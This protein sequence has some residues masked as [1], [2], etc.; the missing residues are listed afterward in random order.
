MQSTSFC[1]DFYGKVMMHIAANAASKR[2]C[3]RNH[4]V[5][6]GVGVGFGVVDTEISLPT[7]DQDFL[8]T[9][10]KL[11]YELPPDASTNNIIGAS[12]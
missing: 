11:F 10:F 4:G 6:V 5:G 9:L 3:Q 2:L 1:G 8:F 7:A 12:V